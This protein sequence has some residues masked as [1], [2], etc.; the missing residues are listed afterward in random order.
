MLAQ[1][2]AS[3]NQAGATVEVIGYEEGTA[4]K[5][6]SFEAAE[7]ARLNFH[8]MDKRSQLELY[9]FMHQDPG[10]PTPVLSVPRLAGGKSS[11]AEDKWLR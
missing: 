11:T 4:L 6:L 10:H 5:L 1:E 8:I 3:R 2:R 7:N 9:A